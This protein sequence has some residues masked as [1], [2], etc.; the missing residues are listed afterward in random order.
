LEARRQGGDPVAIVGYADGVQVFLPLILRRFPLD[1]GSSRVILDATSPYGY[2]PPIVSA[3]AASSREAGARAITAAIEGL[4]S[5]GACCAFIRMHPLLPTPPWALE[6]CGTLVTHGPTVYIDL[7]LSDEEIRRQTRPSDRANL[8]RLVGD[9]FVARVDEGWT[10]FDDFLRIYR[11]TMARVGA[12]PDY[13]FEDRYFQDLRVALGTSLS[14][15]VVEK[16]DDAAAAGLFT[17]TCGIVQF[18]L[19]GTDEAFREDAPSRLML[20]FATKW[21][22]DRGNRWFHLGG[23]LGGRTDSLFGFKAGFSKLRGNFSTWRIVTSPETYADAVRAWRTR[24]GAA[25][26]PGDAY[27]PAYRSP[28]PAVTDST[29]SRR[30][31]DR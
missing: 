31:V 5:L 24:Y 21:A 16:G 18:H 2:C 28:A 30:R 25:A 14:L 1:A 9:G 17:E 10:R 23:G 12:S 4:K 11:E 22:K 27:F 6:S 15:I 29:D 7:R 20:D 13:Y 19:S 8:R 3:G 26:E